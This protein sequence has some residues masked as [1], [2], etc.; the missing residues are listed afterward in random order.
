MNFTGFRTFAVGLATV[1][2]PAA[3][4]YAAGFD[5]TQVVSPTVA[6]MISGALQLGL[7]AITSTPLF[8]KK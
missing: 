1:I 8:A 2:V 7:R 5:W 4:T 6:L 3:L